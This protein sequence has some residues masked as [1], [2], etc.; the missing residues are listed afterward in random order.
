MYDGFQVQ[1][2]ASTH[3]LLGLVFGRPQDMD[4]T[5]MDCR[6]QII[7]AAK[8]WTNSLQFMST[9]DYDTKTSQCTFLLSDKRAKAFIDNDYEVG[10]LNTAGWKLQSSKIKCSDMKVVGDADT[11]DQTVDI[12][13]LDGRGMTDAQVDAWTG[14]M[15]PR[16]LN[17]FAALSGM[18][19]GRGG[20]GSGN[21]LAAL[22]ALRGGPGGEG[23]GCPTQ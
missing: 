16:E 1:A 19:M 2:V 11:W 22:A 6:K 9:F 3:A 14:Q 15:M 4:A 12:P 21:P 17:P 5:E 13:T 23:P 18:G 7:G 20:N 8:T 10:I